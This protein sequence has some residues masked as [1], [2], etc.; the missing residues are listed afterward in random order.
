MIYVKNGQVKESDFVNL[1]SAT[2]NLCVKDVQQNSTKK[3]G[4]V[5]FENLTFQ[6][7]LRASKGTAF[8]GDVVQTG[9]QTFPDIIAKKFF[10]T[11][12]K[13]TTDDKWMSTGNSVLE[14]TRVDGVE[15]IFMFFG[16]FGGGFDI[17][18][19]L[20]QDCL[21]DVGVTH[22]PRYKINMD[23]ANGQSIFNKIGVDY[24]TL[25]KE[26]NPI[27]RIKDYYRK[28]LTDGEELWWIDQPDVVA[29]PIIRSF[30]KFTEEEKTKFIVETMILFPE[31]FG[32]S[33]L[34][35]ERVASYL[36]TNYGA[37]SSNIRDTFTAG[38]QQIVKIGKRKITVPRILYHLIEYAGDIKSTIG[39]LDSAK[40]A[41]YWRVNRIKAN[42]LKQWLGLVD[43]KNDFKDCLASAVFRAGL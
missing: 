6:M 38:G 43:E 35:F 2:K 23:L 20:Y 7:M 4:G 15:R 22:S 25:R 19:R 10:G 37:V 32:S 21:C 16:K 27:Q 36:V 13:T 8:A 31:I 5:E 28:Q 14:T 26:E 24:D 29:N 41:Y 1:L 33:S 9:P 39:A 17:K 18:Y 30:S 12:V 40:L 11:E 3:M 42:R 34:K